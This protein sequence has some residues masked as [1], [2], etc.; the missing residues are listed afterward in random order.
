[1]RY[2]YHTTNKFNK[3]IEKTQLGNNF[4]RCVCL[5]SLCFMTSKRMKFIPNNVKK[6]YT[7]VSNNCLLDYLTYFKIT[8]YFKQ[9]KYS[10]NLLILL[11]VFLPIFNFAYSTCLCLFYF[12]IL[13][14]CK[15]CLK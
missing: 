4:R 11:M 2:L 9:K 6:Q 5:C 12:I 10:L 14:S 7:I 15:L 8:L 13:I 3:K 1:M